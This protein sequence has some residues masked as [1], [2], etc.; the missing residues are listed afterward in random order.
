MNVK[1][2]I[3]VIF[4]RFCFTLKIKIYV[5]Y[6]FYITVS[7]P[8]T[9]AQM[10]EYTLAAMIPDCRQLCSNHAVIAVRTLNCLWG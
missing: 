1:Y 9:Y 4:L 3:N 7:L 2:V 6:L 10:V 5:S 8:H